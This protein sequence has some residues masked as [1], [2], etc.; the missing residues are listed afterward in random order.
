MQPLP[1]WNILIKYINKE[2]KQDE[3][4]KFENWLRLDSKNQKFYNQIKDAWDSYGVD[5]ESY[6]PDKKEGWSR[7][8]NKIEQDSSKYKKMITWS[9]RI[10]ASVLIIIGFSVIIKQFSLKSLPE[11]FI[12]ETTKKESNPKKLLLSD[13]TTVWLNESTSFKFQEKF[14]NNERVV[15]L[16]GE[17][18]Y[19]VAS[20]P[21]RPFIIKTRNTVTEVLGTSFNLKAKELEDIVII[22]VNSGKVIFYPKNKKSDKIIL[23]KGFA[24]YYNKKN[25]KLFKSNE[26]DNNYLSWKTGELFFNKSSLLEVCKTLE[27]N[28]NKTIYIMQPE[29]EQFI[30]TATYKNQTFNEIIE[31]ISQTLDI[32]C[33]IK[34]DSVIFSLN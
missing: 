11:N 22:T 34:N 15:H 3:K 25:K 16:N 1:D 23:T 20:D 28:Y 27:N 18:Y 33:Q 26:F 9:I 21:E 7:I 12:T 31:I 14:N 24:G 30:I 2:C 5:S 19:E 29:L 8:N 4:I 6:F 32:K 10:A 13:G 17:A